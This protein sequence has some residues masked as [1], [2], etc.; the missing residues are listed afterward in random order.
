VYN[1]EVQSLLSIYSLS[2]KCARKRSLKIYHTPN[3]SLRFF[4]KYW[5]RSSSAKRKV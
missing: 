5:V 4:V 3:V 2:G 1:T